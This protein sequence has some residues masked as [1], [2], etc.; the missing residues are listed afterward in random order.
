[1]AP[2]DDAF[3]FLAN[4]GSEAVDSAIKL[5]RLQRGKKKI[6]AAQNSFHGYTLG[7]LS[8]SGI[9]SFKR[10]FAP[11]LPEISHI[12]YNDIAAL[13]EAM[14]TEIAALILEPVQ[15]EAGVVVPDTAYFREVRSIC[16][17]NGALLIMDE[18]KTGCGRTGRMF[19]S[20]H[21]GIVPDMI[22]L[23]KSLGGGLMPI[24]A[25]IAGEKSAK[26]I[27]SQFLHVGI[28]L[29]RNSLACQAAYTTLQI[30]KQDGLIPEAARKGRG[31]WSAWRQ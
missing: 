15:H 20:E 18:I 22:L 12:P 16:D 14:T 9:P 7:A 5:A 29:R 2:I 24:G 30:L 23:G 4:S 31:S 28:I 6:L 11:L 19:A 25:L 3:V 10:L 27:Q 8:V 13:R 26:K 21:Y 17:E 1:M